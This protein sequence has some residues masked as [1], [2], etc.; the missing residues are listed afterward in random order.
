MD[1]ILEQDGIF[2]RFFY[3]QEFNP[4]ALYKIEPDI[5]VAG[6]SAIRYIDV[7]HA[8][9]VVNGVA[10][11]SAIRYID[12]NHA[13]EVVNK[14][15]REDVVG[16]TFGEVW[17]YVEP[18]WSEIIERC[19]RENRA[20][21]CESESVYTDNYLEAIAFPLPHGRAATIFLDRTELKKSEE[22]LKE[23]QKKLLEYRSMLRELAT[24]LTISEETTRRE[25]A[26]D[27]HDS[28]GHSLL[29]LMLD[30]RRLKEIYK[31]DGEAGL[32]I[33]N[34]IRAT[35]EMITE[36]RAL[37]FELSP[38][39]LLEVGITPALE[40]L[41]DKL[42]IPRGIKW[43]VTTRGTLKDYPA[44]DAVCIILYR[45]SREVL[46]NVRGPNKIQ[47]VIEDDGVGMRPDLAEKRGRKKG[48]LGLFS[49][50][51]RLLHI[52]GELRIISNESGTTVSMLAPLKLRT[53]DEEEGAEA[54]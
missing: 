20:V 16:R 8:Y 48:G 37:I 4:I 31:G 15:K 1:G 29:A 38:P 47:V 39:I 54:E 26:T 28:I 41:A 14:V 5:G 22:E 49:I 10:G 46:I 9:E 27:L 23:K 42:L 19:V 52:G 53:G 17:P 24:Q 7:N 33:D 6:S 51:E 40:A 45:M 44:D 18:C 35:E 25:I 12:V 50:R 3:E 36:S 34:S 43:Y 32:I 13:Y 21:H 2:A 11:S 30:L